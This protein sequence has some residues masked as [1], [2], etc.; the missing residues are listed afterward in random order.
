MEATH[1]A[2]EFVAR[3]K[4]QMIC[5]G[6]KD[7]DAKRFEVCLCLGFDSCRRSHGHERRRIYDAMRRRQ[8]AQPCAG[9]ISCN[10]F[11]LKF[12]PSESIRR[13]RP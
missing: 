7:L 2:D 4:K 1:I 11:K 13:T 8:P 9:W 5:V 6:K 3:A 12:H 10:Y